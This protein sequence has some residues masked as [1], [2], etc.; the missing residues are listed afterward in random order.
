MLSYT[1]RLLRRSQFF[2]ASYDKRSSWLCEATN[3]AGTLCGPG[4]LHEQI[5][6]ALHM[7]FVISVDLSVA[8][9][10]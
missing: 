4:G 5:S 2:N 9:R 1:E 3:P 10:T 8:W 7:Y 6:G